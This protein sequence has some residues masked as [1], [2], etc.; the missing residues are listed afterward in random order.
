MTRKEP[1]AD[2]VVIG[3]GL[4]GLVAART[5]ID[6]GRHVRLLEASDG[7]GGRVRTDEVD[8][9]LLDRGFQLYNPAYPEGLRQLDH[10]ALRLRPFTRG[11]VLHHRGRRI[12]LA[13]P[14][15]RSSAAA[16]V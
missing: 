8:G 10:K 11:A 6:A 12:R 13:D 4:A 2:V 9:Y 7:V 5:L 14:S 1:D 3:A 15:S 16:T